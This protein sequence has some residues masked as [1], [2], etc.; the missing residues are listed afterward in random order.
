M[1]LNEHTMQLF[2]IKDGESTQGT[3]LSIFRLAKQIRKYLGKKGYLLDNYLATY[4]DCICCIP[5]EEVADAGFQ[6]AGGFQ[7][8]FFSLL[9]GTGDKNA[10]PLYQSMENSF[11]QLT[12]SLTY[13]EK[14]TKVCL[15]FCYHAD[16][17][18]AYAATEFREEYAQKLQDTMM[19]ELHFEDLYQQITNL[20]GK[21]MIDDLLHKLHQFFLADLLEKVFLRGFFEDLAHRLTDRDAETGKLMFQLF[22]DH[23]PDSTE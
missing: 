6:A 16:D 12:D 2:G 23:L 14:Y 21:Q 13:Q 18:L 8:I 3:L 1:D 4:L 11:Q 17:M 15:L 22:I 19:D 9:N 10:H 20:A 7:A 5:P